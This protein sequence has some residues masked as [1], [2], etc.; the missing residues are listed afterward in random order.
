MS[1]PG[2][3]RVGPHRG[4]GDSGAHKTTSTMLVTTPAAMFEL[5]LPHIPPLGKA[6]APPRTPQAP[7]TPSL[8]F[9]LAESRRISPPSRI[10]ASS[11]APKHQENDFISLALISQ[12]ITPETCT[13]TIRCGP[14]PPP[15]GYANSDG[16]RRG[17]QGASPGG[18][19][20]AAYRVPSRSLWCRLLLHR[21]LSQIFRTPD[22][23]RYSIPQ[24]ALQHSTVLKRVVYF[25]TS[26][27]ARRMHSRAR[28]LSPRC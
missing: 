25:L 21:L 15:G 16:R 10:Q 17:V 20:E 26:S 14:N 3:A 2:V 8:T 19:R 1:E 7:L 24:A 11:E 23:F 12:N 5:N 9:L 6:S 18:R 13:L 22:E 28:H 27:L 4:R